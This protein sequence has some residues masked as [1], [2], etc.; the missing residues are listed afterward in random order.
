MNLENQRKYQLTFIK[1]DNNKHIIQVQS[2]TDSQKIKIN[3]P[4]NTR[5]T[6]DI[7]MRLDSQR[8]RRPL[9]L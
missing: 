6:I 7:V 8:L 4:R 9:V 3:L 1:E 2:S 5:C